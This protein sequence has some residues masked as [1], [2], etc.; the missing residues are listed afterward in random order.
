MWYISSLILNNGRVTP[1][2]G[3]WMDVGQ[4][5]DFLTGMSMYLQS[6][7]E[8]SPGKLYEGDYIIGNALI[9]GTTQSLNLSESTLH[10]PID[11]LSFVM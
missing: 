10:L 4:P 9:V 2:T 8:K 3:F 7:R 11:C 6:L 1:Q 5:K